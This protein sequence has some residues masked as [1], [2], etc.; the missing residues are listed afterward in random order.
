MKIIQ[1]ENYTEG[2]ATIDFEGIDMISIL[3]MGNISILD[4][5]KFKWNR[6]VGSNIGDCPFYIGAM[7]IFATEKLG[8]ILGAYNVNTATF[9]VEDK[10]YT[11]ISPPHLEGKVIN[12]QESKCRTFRSGKIMNVDKF[13]F[14]KD[15]NYPVLFTPEEY[16]MFTFCNTEL[17][18][19]LIS[20]HFDQLKLT[21]CDMH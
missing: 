2:Y 11:I 8:T 17:A 21:E 14:N 16:V 19:K 1:L 13:V 9:S 18:Q 20:C 5:K 15:I 3:K 4:G 6:E 12:T 7:P 10:E